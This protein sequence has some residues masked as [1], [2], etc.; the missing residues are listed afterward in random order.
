MKNSIGLHAKEISFNRFRRERSKNR[1][2]NKMI[3]EREQKKKRVLSRSRKKR[4]GHKT[5]KSINRSRIETKKSRQGS[6]KRKHRSK[7]K[8]RSKSSSKSKSRSNSKKS[9]KKRKTSSNLQFLEAKNIDLNE[10]MNK[11]CY[12]LEE[13]KRISKKVSRRNK[14]FDKRMKNLSQYD[15]KGFQNEMM[16]LQSELIQKITQNYSN[17]EIV[18]NKIFLSIEKYLFGRSLSKKPKN[19]QS[20][21][22]IQNMQEGVGKLNENS[23]NNSFNINIDS[24]PSNFTVNHN[25]FTPNFAEIDMIKASIESNEE[26]KKKAKSKVVDLETSS[27]LDHYEITPKG[28]CD[29]FDIGLASKEI[30]LR[31]KNCD[32]STVELEK[33]TSNISEISKKEDNFS[34]YHNTF[35]MTGFAEEKNDFS[36]P[37]KVK[38]KIKKIEGKSELMKIRVQNPMNIKE[39]FDKKSWLKPFATLPNEGY[40]EEK[41]IKESD[42]RVKKTIIDIFAKKNDGS[43]FEE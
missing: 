17:V 34:S 21:I 43:K 39:I 8:S 16:V 38:I 2:K 13:F 14:L 15:K 22:S 20:E 35:G 24:K 36:L 1:V 3:K 29:S 7:S 28:M 23:G 33:K 12:L 26:K 25:I 31:D 11:M 10:L 18:I 30:T 27:D 5:N 41:M 32:S 40:N 9:K 19:D 37:N 42:M 4:N 6:R